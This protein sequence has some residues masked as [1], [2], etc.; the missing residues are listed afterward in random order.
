LAVLSALSL[1]ARRQETVEEDEAALVARAR[2][3]VDAF[4]ELYRRHLP[5]VYRYLLGRAGDEED[6]ADL[7]QQAFAAAYASIDRYRGR[8][9]FLAWVLRIARNAAIDAGRRRRPAISWESVSEYRHPVADE[10]VESMAVRRETLHRLRL[11]LAALPEAKRD[12]LALRFGAGLTCREIGAVLNISEA[13]AKKRLE[14]T[15]R[16]LEAVY[17]DP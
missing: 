9:P 13:A 16:E 7:T 12:L 6:A 17:H 3:D 10:S 11:L 1:A 15:L 14:R 8:G 2:S 4:A 5:A